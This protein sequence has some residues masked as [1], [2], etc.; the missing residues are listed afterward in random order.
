VRDVIL[1]MAD[2]EEA[3]AHFERFDEFVIDIET[4]GE[5]RGVPVA[6]EILW[7]ALAT[8]GRAVVIP[9]GHPNG[10]RLISKATW[11]KNKQTGE[12]ETIPA[13]WSAPPKQL[14]PSQV[15]KA[16]EPL[17]F[18][19]R[20]KVAHS[21]TFDLGSLAKYYGGRIPPKPYG[22]TLVGSWLLDEN[23]LNGL[24]TLVEK[25]YKHKYDTENVGKEVEKYGF[26]TVARY[27]YLDAKYTWL[28][29]RVMCGDL[30]EQNLSTIMSLELGVTEVL[31]DMHPTGAHIDEDRLLELEHE[32]VIKLEEIKTRLFRAA[33]K[34][35]NVG[36]PLQ[37][38]DILFG[39][40][41]KGGQGLKPIKLTDGGKAKKR[42][43]EKPGFR[44][45]STDAETLETYPENEVCRILL[46][47]AEVDKLLS[48]YVYGYLGKANQPRRIFNGR[49]HPIFKQY[50]ARTGRFSCSAPNLQNVPR[51]G[52][53]LGTKV[54]SLFI[55]PKGH[56]L[57]VADWGQ[58]ELRVLAHYLG[59]GA[60]YEGFLAG[61]DAHTATAALVYGVA[62][63]DVTKEMRQVAKGL[64]FAIVYGAGPETVA[65]MANITVREAERIM[66]IHEEQFPE[67]Y[68][69]KK[70]VVATVRKRSTHDLTTLLG[71]KRRLPEIVSNL[72]WLRSKGE[73]RAVNSLIQGSSADLIKL[74]MI[75]LNKSIK[76]SGHTGIKLSLTVHDE[77]V[78]I[79]PEDQVDVGSKILQEAMIG[80]GI[81]HLIN[82]PLTAD[83]AVCDRWSDAKD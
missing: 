9:M 25:R 23:R 16:L 31:L 39:P 80:E 54:R 49:I 26:G 53:E 12:R 35:F 56:K 45:W 74:A 64:N 59:R 8:H 7:I 36:S 66:Q 21:A 68:E 37:R 13:V 2:L 1:T 28:L 43:G 61:V 73:R 76:E 47:F 30:V 69:F 44:D 24:K 3:V 57:L 51:P 46:E 20:R 72:G 52:T 81:Q 27:A 79:C 82:V 50:G 58:I 83:V 71:R 65:A 62:W 55:A 60:L 11:R 6:N 70:S 18:S 41:S 38:Q 5:H 40:K 67:I 42:N 22:C 33:G 32:L 63:E 14:R 75:R 48:T 17:I 19:S 77:L 15:F 78:V 10:D 4:V 29:W 34:V